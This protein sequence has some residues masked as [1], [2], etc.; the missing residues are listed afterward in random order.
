MKN[1]LTTTRLS[2]RIVGRNNNFNLFRMLA[3]LIVSVVHF[4]EVGTAGLVKKFDVFSYIALD[5]F[6]VCSGFLI[7]ASI[8]RRKNLGEYALAR[9]FRIFPALIVVSF[10]AA[11]VLGPVVTTLPISDYFSNSSVYSYFAITSLTTTPH[12]RLPGVFENLVMLGEVNAPIWTLKYELGLY[13]ATALAFS[14]G[15]LQSKNLLIIAAISVF[16]GYMATLAIPY[17]L[18]HTTAFKHSR[19]FAIAFLLGTLA[20]VFSHRILLNWVLVVFSAA[21]AYVFKDSVAGELLALLWAAYF[22]IWFAYLKAPLLLNYNKL[23]DY[24]YGTYIMHWPVFC[25][26]VTIWPGQHL[27]EYVAVG[28]IAVVALAIISW[29]IIEK[30]MLAIVKNISEFNKKRRAEPYNQRNVGQVNQG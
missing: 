24:S 10:I 20:Y 13:C 12:M 5:F 4:I 8:L 27:L 19:H 23:G 22:T 3:A 25:L 30:P 1:L 21:L 2:E 16:F 11:V 17:E 7:A 28:I 9:I 26:M 14:F 6:F 15:I 29:H 18:F